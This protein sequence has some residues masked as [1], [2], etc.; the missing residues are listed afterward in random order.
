M[1]TTQTIQELPLELIGML[2]TMLDGEDFLAMRGTCREL[3]DGSAFKFCQRYLDLVEISGTRDSVHH[4]LNILTSPSLPQTQQTVRK[5]VVSAPRL[6]PSE[7]FE[8]P[9][10]TDVAHLL[11]AMPNL[12]TAK[13]AEDTNLAES[14]REAQSASIFLA[15]MAQLPSRV[16]RLDLFAVQLHG[17]PLANMLEAHRKDLYILSFNVVTLDSLSAW[18]RVLRTMRSSGIRRLEMAWLKYVNHKDG[19]GDISILKGKL[20]KLKQK[21]GGRGFVSEDYGEATRGCVK[22]ALEIILQRL[23]SHVVPEN[24]AEA[25]A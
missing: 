10:T 19:S 21:R 5:L 25:N 22:Q 23:G 11:R 18:Q 2:A 17:D 13:L 8:E 1:S 20:L 4:L 14:L 24:G 6:R 9:K 16:C 12:T 3:R 15:S 7:A